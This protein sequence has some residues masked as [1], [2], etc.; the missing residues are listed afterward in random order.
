MGAAA[1]DEFRHVV[2]DLLVHSHGRW[3]AWSAVWEQVPAGPGGRRILGVGGRAFDLGLRPHSAGY[4]GRGSS[5]RRWSACSRKRPAAGSSPT[6]DSPTLPH[7]TCRRSRSMARGRYMLPPAVP[8]PAVATTVV[9][10]G[11]APRPCPEWPAHQCGLFFRS[12]PSPG[13]GRRAGRGI[14]V[15]PGR[16]APLWSSSRRRPWTGWDTGAPTGRGPPAAL[17]SVSCRR[18]TPEH[19]TS[20]R[21]R[22]VGRMSCPP[23]HTG[24][25]RVLVVEDH[26]TL[27]DQIAQGCARPGWLW[28]PRTTA[29]RRWTPPPRRPMT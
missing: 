11:T 22:D 29:R 15:R 1:V 24:A 25:M 26:A 7:P 8:G 4:R 10:T 16:G 23:T 21:T 9:A 28:I 17:E 27:A 5:G 13:S 19:L 2:L 3:D 20:A 18:S 12:M 14:G 6:G